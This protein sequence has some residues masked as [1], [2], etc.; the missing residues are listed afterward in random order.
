M[1]TIVFLILSLSLAV[2]CGSQDAA[3]KQTAQP[4]AQPQLAEDSL[5]ATA[6]RNLLSQFSGELL[7][8]LEAALKENGAPYAVGICQR[9][10][11]EIAAAHTG[12]GWTV[13]RVSEKWRHVSG[14]PDK[15]E[16]GILASFADTSNHAESQT[17]WSGPD[18]SRVFSY[19]QKITVR[20]MCLQC[21]GDIQVPDPDLWKQIRMEYPYDKATGYKVGDLRGMF[22]ISAHLPTAEAAAKRLAAG[23][24]FKEIVGADSTAAGTK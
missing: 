2:S 22:V 13:K 3:N 21:H 1:K 24:S 14:V 18:S 23:A 9:K 6:A 17:L 15:T 16:K 5:Y 19:Y 7:S 11:Q 12:A 20:E 10:A 8:T 4:Q